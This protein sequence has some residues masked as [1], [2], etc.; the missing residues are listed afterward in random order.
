MAT[1]AAAGEEFFNLDQEMQ[2]TLKEL[3]A[4]G[5]NLSDVFDEFSKLHRSFINVHNSEMRYLKRTE[6][7]TSDISKVRTQM[8]EMKEEDDA[9]R[10]RKDRMQSDIE[11]TWKAVS[12]SNAR[13]SK[14]KP[15]PVCTAIGIYF[16]TP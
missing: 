12:E 1:D 5:D 16:N 13:E 2:K 15:K 11:R 4:R 14:K 6:E 3:E 10:E 9:S 7:L 8:N